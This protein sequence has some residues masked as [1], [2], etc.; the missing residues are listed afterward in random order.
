MSLILLGACV[1]L[2]SWELGHLPSPSDPD[3]D[4]LGYGWVTHAAL[5]LLLFSSV[6][7]P[8]V[9]LLLAVV[10]LFHNQLFPN[11]TWLGFMGCLLLFLLSRYF[12]SM[13]FGS[14]DYVE[15]QAGPI[16]WLLD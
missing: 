5:W 12:M 7:P 6:L 14:N 10:W 16:F 15:G 2:A 13:F 1:A 3:V 11:R 9:F 4:T 8:I